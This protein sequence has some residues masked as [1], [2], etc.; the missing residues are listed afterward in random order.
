MAFF[1]F[2]QNLQLDYNSVKNDGLIK[3]W[4]VRVVKRLLAVARSIISQ[5]EPPAPDFE[6]K[7][8]YIAKLLPK[9]A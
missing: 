9:I 6:A 2:I 3:C 5:T 4:I 1:V 8:C 7:T